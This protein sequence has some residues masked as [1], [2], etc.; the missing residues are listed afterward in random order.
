MNNKFD[1]DKEINRRNTGSLKW[2]VPENE[3]PLWV[4]D[5]DFETAPAVRKAL[6]KRVEHGVFGYSVL[7]DCWYQAYQDWWKKR[8][9]L[10]IEKDWLIFCTGVIPALS[11]A[12]RKLTT[13][14]E[15]ILI[16]TPVYNIFF[17]SIINNGRFVVESP[18]SY[19]NGRYTINWE[20]LE[21]KLSDSQVSMMILCNPHNP[22][23][24]IWDADTLSRIGELC[25]KH[26]VVVFSD[27]IHCDLTAPGKEYI[28][29]ASVSDVCAAISVTAIAPT[30]AFNIAGLQT[31]AVM[32]PDPFLRHRMWRALNTDEVAEPNAFAVD[33]AVAAFE[34]GGE[35]LDALREY[36]QENKKAA[37]QF[38]Q[39]EMP[40][41]T[42]GSLD[43]TYLMWLDCS[44]VTDDSEKLSVYLREKAGVYLSEGNIFG[45]NGAQ[46]LR[47]N[48]ATTRKNLMEGLRRFKK[49]IEGR[50]HEKES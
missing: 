2:D 21:T 7:P 4:A 44:Q 47:L 39:T 9:H 29:F 27:E 11:T 45:G 28:P 10:E 20:D 26:H 1:F 41:I 24:N 30:K 8:H 23:G 13:P 36:L 33:V 17:N 50:C 22:V 42:T 14:G 43:V 5:M 34:E 48:T 32:V 19:E 3:L 31:A 38:I 18:L 25:R 37:A 49:G 35:W 40:M 46:F 15:K 16:Q 12:V 6:Q